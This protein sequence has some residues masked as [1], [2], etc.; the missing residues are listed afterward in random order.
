[1]V[2]DWSQGGGHKDFSIK[3][4]Q[5]GQQVVTNYKTKVLNPKWAKSGPKGP[6]E[7]LK[8]VARM[9]DQHVIYK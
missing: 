8:N 4:T 2:T 5:C 3:I 7:P 9:E 6:K 1:M